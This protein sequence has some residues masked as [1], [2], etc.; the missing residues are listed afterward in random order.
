MSKSKLFSV[1]AAILFI[2]AVVL[3]V[4]GADWVTHREVTAMEMRIAERAIADFRT[5][6]GHLPESLGEA[7][8][9]LGKSRINDKWGDSFIYVVVNEETAFLIS[10]RDRERGPYDALF[11][12]CGLSL[13][14][15]KANH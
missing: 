15:Q 1:A 10:I 9:P 3:F 8:E 14:Q 4:F 12:E 5:R 11:L 6:N 7:L 13:S 2:F